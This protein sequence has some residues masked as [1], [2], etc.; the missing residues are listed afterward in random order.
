M[1]IGEGTNKD[2]FKNGELGF[3]TKFPPQQHRSLQLMPHRPSSSDSSINSTSCLPSLVNTIQ[4]YSNFTCFI[5]TPLTRRVHC[6]GL[7]ESCNVSVF[8]TPIFIP[9]LRKQI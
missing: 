3:Y 8:A 4:R 2:R 9:A 5:G 1:T 6:P 7:L